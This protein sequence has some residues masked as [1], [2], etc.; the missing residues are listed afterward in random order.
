LLKYFSISSGGNMS[1]PAG[2]GVCVVK[3]L[4]AITSWR[5]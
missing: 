2:T 5:T 4:V 3:M 1:I